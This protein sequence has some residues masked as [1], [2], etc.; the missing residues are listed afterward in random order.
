MADKLIKTTGC[1][2]CQEARNFVAPK[3]LP[4]V[5]IAIR[6]P[7]ETHP[8]YNGKWVDILRLKF[9]DLNVAAGGQEPATRE[10]VKEIYD[11][12][13]KYKDHHIMA[14]CEAGISRS[15]A[16]RQFLN[17]RGWVVHRR[18]LDHRIHPNVHILNWLKYFER[19]E[20]H[21]SWPT[22]TVVENS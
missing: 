18:L 5:L 22:A 1:M 20:E 12:I 2:S 9:W 4:A 3:G 14:H 21:Y 8:P 6:D 16:I 13:Q 11:F 15:G 19:G 17:D 10:Q 7:S